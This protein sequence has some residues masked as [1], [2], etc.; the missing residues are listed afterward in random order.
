MTAALFTR[1]SGGPSVLGRFRR[2]GSSRSSGTREVG[3]DR[4]RFAAGRL[5][6]ARRSRGSCRGGGR[7][8]CCL[9]AALTPRR[10]RLLSANRFAMYSPMPR[11]APVTIAILPSSR[12]TTGCFCRRVAPRQFRGSGCSRCAD[13]RTARTLGEVGERRPLEDRGSSRPGPL[14]T[15]RASSSRSSSDTAPGSSVSRTRSARAGLGTAGRRPRGVMSFGSLFRRYP[16][17]GPRS[18]R[19]I[20]VV[21]ELEHHLLEDGGGHLRALAD[22]LELDRVV[23]RREC[24]REQRAR[25]VVR[26]LRDPHDPP[27]RQLS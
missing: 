5:D 23:A 13:P 22:R 11:L 6:R 7:R 12:P 24:E 21:A 9:G 8:V 17:T 16:P 3:S 4:D 14:P 20:A 26:S 25:R 27:S 10:L 15:R 19:T 1:M 2:S 18:E